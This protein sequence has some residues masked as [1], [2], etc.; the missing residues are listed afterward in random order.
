MHIHIMCLVRWRSRTIFG[1]NEDGSYYYRAMKKGSLLMM[2]AALM[3]CGMGCTSND[4]TATTKPK[5]KIYVAKNIRTGSNLPQAFTDPQSA[6]ASNDVPNPTE[7]AQH[8]F[9][10]SVNHGNGSGSR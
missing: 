6:Q 1:C 7:A 5:R 3:M 10:D 2:A 8:P 4:S 9:F